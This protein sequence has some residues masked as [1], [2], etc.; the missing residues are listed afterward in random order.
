MIL[1]YSSSW[2]PEQSI[3]AEAQASL[4]FLWSIKDLALFHG[5][6]QTSVH[7]PQEF[8]GHSLETTGMEREM[9]LVPASG[10]AVQPLISILQEERAPWGA[11]AGAQLLP[12]STCTPSSSSPLTG[13]E[14]PS[15]P[16]PPQSP[17]NPAPRGH[18]AL[19][20][21]FVAQH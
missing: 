17:C 1:I 8:G 7:N 4:C 21:W 6:L 13:R 12:F 20:A 9:D 18:L 5:L 10:A 3:P 15:P 11:P 14:L 19:S 16:T 2:A